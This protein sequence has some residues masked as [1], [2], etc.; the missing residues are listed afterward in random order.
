METEFIENSDF[1]FKKMSAAHILLQIKLKRKKKVKNINIDASIDNYHLLE[2]GNK[3]F[4]NNDYK[5]KTT[6]QRKFTSSVLLSNRK[7]MALQVVTS[8]RKSLLFV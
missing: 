3:Y 5:F 6:D 1:T 7:A 8:S 4:T 2:A